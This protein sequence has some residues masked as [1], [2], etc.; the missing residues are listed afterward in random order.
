VDVVYL[1]CE[2]GAALGWFSPSV[3][4]LLLLFFVASSASFFF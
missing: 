1:L 3:A 4:I 2:T